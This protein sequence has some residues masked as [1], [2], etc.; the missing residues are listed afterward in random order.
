MPTARIRM[1]SDVSRSLVLFLLLCLFLAVG[2]RPG[3][4][5]GPARSSAG[6][7]WFS[8]YVLDDNRDDPI[9]GV[10]VVLTGYNLTTQKWDLIDRTDTNQSGYYELSIIEEQFNYNQVF[11]EADNL[12][13]YVSTNASSVGGTVVDWDTIRYDAPWGSKTRV[14]NNFWDTYA[15]PTATPTQTPLPTCLLYTSPSPRDRTRSRMPSSA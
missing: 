14:N 13:D 7:L 4:S 8:G 15:P 3:V 5:A 2:L 9:P 10:T 12:P 1:R 11:I 6:S